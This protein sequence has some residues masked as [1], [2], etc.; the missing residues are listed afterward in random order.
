MARAGIGDA[1]ERYPQLHE[2]KRE[3]PR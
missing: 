3:A 2:M 1:T